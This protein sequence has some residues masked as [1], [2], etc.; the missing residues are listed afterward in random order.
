MNFKE[1]RFSFKCVS[2]TR[3]DVLVGRDI[4][5][6]NITETTPSWS[7]PMMGLMELPQVEENDGSVA[8]ACNGTDLTVNGRDPVQEAVEGWEQ[9]GGPA[10]RAGHAGDVL[11]V[12]P[13]APTGGFTL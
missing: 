7:L 2:I 9:G 10:A 6:L 8:L 4:K 13:E 5:T 1:K 11:V 3:H 12:R